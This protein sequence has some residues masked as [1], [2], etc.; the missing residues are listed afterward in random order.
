M[1]IIRR[2]QLLRGPEAIDIYLRFSEEVLHIPTKALV[3]SRR[4]EKL[5][6]AS[7]RL[8]DMSKSQEYSSDCMRSIVLNYLMMT[9]S[10]LIGN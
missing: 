10:I 5:K 2:V 7:E 8:K 4:D 6:K 3:G 1:N 9:S